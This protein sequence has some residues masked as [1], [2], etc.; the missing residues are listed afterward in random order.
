[1]TLMSAPPTTT[2]IVVPA[3]RGSTVTLHR[4]WR[5]ALLAALAVWSATTVA[6]LAVS[7]LAWL[8]RGGDEIPGLTS[9]LLGWNRWDAGHY[10]QI[11]ESG[12][13]L[14][15]GYP[16]F[17]PLYPLLIRLF[18]PLLP[19]G[20]LISAL[21]IANAAA[22]GTLAVLHRLADHEFG[23]RAAQRTI[24]YLAAFP[25]GFFLFIGYNESLFILLSLSALYAARRGHW[26]LAG[27]L[28]GL[29]SGARL[30]GLLL[31]V[32]LAIEYLRQIGWRPR[33]IRP[34]VAALAL[35][36]VGLLSYSV[37]CLV[38]LGDPL[39]FSVAQD[40]WGREYTVPGGALLTA[41]QQTGGHRLL[42]PV[43]IAALLDAGTVLVAIGLLVLCLAGPYRFR[44]DQVYLVVHAALAFAVLTTTEVGGRA[45]MSASRFTLEAAAV[46]LVLARIGAGRTADRTILVIGMA[47]QAVFLAT[48]MVGA[49][50][51]A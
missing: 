20:A 32:P 22:F 7:A 19:G 35:V 30:F 43:T 15:P 2:P 6:R 48:Y 45:M 24:W 14:G 37:Y 9:I 29:S 40:Q 17:Y 36:P 4:P 16:A 11:A 39:A 50:M 18:D 34:D 23:P 8:P 44:R 25:T 1:M 28:G 3:Q 21:V 42:D 31:V 27:A 5:A 49:F 51:V 33:R 12:Y 13:H 10:V 26:W 38:E 46:F 47:L 41:F